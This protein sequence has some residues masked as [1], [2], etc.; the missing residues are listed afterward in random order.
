MTPDQLKELLSA[1]AQAES[2][3]LKLHKH[4]EGDL[5]KDLLIRLNSIRLLIMTEGE[6][7]HKLIG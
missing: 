5:V 6:K 3:L 2:N 1:I 7:I 4:M